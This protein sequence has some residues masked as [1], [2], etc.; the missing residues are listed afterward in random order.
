MYWYFSFVFMYCFWIF[1]VRV[2]LF[3]WE[4][5]SYIKPIHDT[6]RFCVYTTTTLILTNIN[7]T[8]IRFR[9]AHALIDFGTVAIE[10][11]LSISYFKVKEILLAWPLNE[12]FVNRVDSRGAECT[13]LQYICLDNGI[14][15]YYSCRLHFW[16]NIIGNNTISVKFYTKI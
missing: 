13:L 4:N 6:R 3:M 10:W 16:N 12:S 5:T 11:L 9:S 15:E 1:V 2:C 14:S 7:T 8:H